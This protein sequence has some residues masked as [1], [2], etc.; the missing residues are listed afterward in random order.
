MGAQ[1]LWDAPVPRA[2]WQAKGCGA[3]RCSRSSPPQP[4]AFPQVSPSPFCQPQKAASI[5]SLHPLL[6]KA[7]R[8][9]AYLLPQTPADR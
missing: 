8:A 6:G 1:G 4:G 7:T 5:Q 2:C 9:S 3:T